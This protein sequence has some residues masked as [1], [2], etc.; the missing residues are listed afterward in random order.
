VLVVVLEVNATMMLV[1][2]DVVMLV[3]GRSN[4]A[5]VFVVITVLL[6]PTAMMVWLWM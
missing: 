5:G 1:A 3:L 2:A 4:C 6:V